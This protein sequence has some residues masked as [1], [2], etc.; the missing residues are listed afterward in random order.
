MRIYVAASYPNKEAAKELAATLKAMGHEIMSGWVFE[1]EGYG[2]EPK[3][4]NETELERFERLQKS[5][6]RDYLEVKA[7][8]MIVCIT[9]GENQLTHGGRHS[10]LGLAMAWSKEI[11]ILGPRE[12]VFHYHTAI[13][14]YDNVLEFFQDLG[15]RK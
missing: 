10:E 8:D 11:V 14:Q 5:A 1:Y 7:S 3:F 15:L 2:S 4:E 9:D 6:E 12:Q 13:K